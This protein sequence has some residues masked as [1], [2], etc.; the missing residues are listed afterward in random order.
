[1]GCRHR[2]RLV[3]RITL[4]IRSPN[5]TGLSPDHASKS[6]ELLWAEVLRF[7]LPR[8]AKPESHDLVKDQVRERWINFFDYQ[9]LRRL[10]S[11]NTLVSSKACTIRGHSGREE[12]AERYSSSG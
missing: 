2:R 11:G 3:T 4:R 10:P 9:F 1:M 8:R 6:T 7:H 5:T 12:D